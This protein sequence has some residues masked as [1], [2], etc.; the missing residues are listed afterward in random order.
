MW[1]SKRRSETRV[2]STKFWDLV[3]TRIPRMSQWRLKRGN[4]VL[5]PSPRVNDPLAFVNA[6]TVAGA[7]ASSIVAAV[8][9]LAI[10]LG[11]VIGI[12]GSFE[13]LI[14]SRLDPLHR[15]RHSRR[16]PRLSSSFSCSVFLFCS[17]VRDSI[18]NDFFLDSACVHEDV[19]HLDLRFFL[20]IEVF[21]W[22]DDDEERERACVID[23]A[24]SAT[25]IEEECANKFTKVTMCLDYG[26]GKAAQPSSECCSSVKD[27]KIKDSACLCFFIQQVHSGG[28]NLKSLGLQEARILQ[29]PKA[30]GI[31]A[32]LS[33]CAKSSDNQLIAQGSALEE[34][35]R[36]DPGYTGPACG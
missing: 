23:L 10:V 15:L 5:L 35:S 6:T 34:T 2:K 21:D 14:Y 12:V 32:T 17:V 24:F 22:N 36:A 7:L 1:R 9:A 16:S 27:I 26:T 33:D 28:P 20:R 8:G 30:C 19:G 13:G 31:N 3:Q 18:L 29:L 11:F 25:S 4:L